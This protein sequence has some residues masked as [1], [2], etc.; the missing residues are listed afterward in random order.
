LARWAL[1]HLASKGRSGLISGL[2]ALAKP[3]KLREAR[4]PALPLLTSKNRS[5]DNTLTWAKV[6]LIAS[7][8]HNVTCVDALL[9][10]VREKVESGEAV[11]VP[12]SAL[13]SGRRA[14][15]EG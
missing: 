15:V 9:E 3:L 8:A 12:W 13:L 6:H 4:S 14:D 2:S 10:L 5:R 1:L 11:V 7:I